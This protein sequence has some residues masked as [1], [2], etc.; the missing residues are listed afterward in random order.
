MNIL[1]GMASWAD[2]SLMESG[3]IYPPELVEAGGL[4][5]PA[6]GAVGASVRGA[7]TILA[8]SDA[9]EPVVAGV[10]QL[11]RSPAAH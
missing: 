4:S 10:P 3:K 5:F 6:V 7:A 2:K 8:S 9:R 11:F 1:V